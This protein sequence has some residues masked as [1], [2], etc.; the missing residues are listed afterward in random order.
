M[1]SIRDPRGLLSFGEAGNPLPFVPVR[2]FTVTEV[3]ADAVRGQHA[4]RECHEFL[5]AVTGSCLVEITDGAHRDAVSLE[6]IDTGLHI[7]PLTWLT[8]RDFAAGTV[9]L[10]LASHPFEEADYIRGYDQFLAVVGGNP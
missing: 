6:G 8:L 1:N 4:H 5:V 7:P 9:L 2:Y 3:P 10:V